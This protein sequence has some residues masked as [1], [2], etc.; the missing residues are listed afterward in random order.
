MGG[1]SVDKMLINTKSV[2]VQMELNSK[3][4]LPQLKERIQYYI[5]KEKAWLIKEK[6]KLTILDH[7]EDTDMDI[8]IQLLGRAGSVLR[9]YPSSKRIDIHA[10]IEFLKQEKAKQL[11]A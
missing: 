11:E 9:Y 8:W 10:I 5:S 7:V 2:N 1:L 3:D 4:E 6:V